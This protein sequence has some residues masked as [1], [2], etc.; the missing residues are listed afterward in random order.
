MVEDE[1]GG[2]AE[3]TY[4]VR[5]GGKL[6]GVQEFL[7]SLAAEEGDVTDVDVILTIESTSDSFVTDDDPATHAILTPPFKYGPSGSPVGKY[8]MAEWS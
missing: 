3:Y 7:E 2:N 1:D 8:N 6:V 5:F 4:Q